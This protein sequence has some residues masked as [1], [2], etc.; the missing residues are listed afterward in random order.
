[1][2]VSCFSNCTGSTNFEIKIKI[3]KKKILDSSI[4]LSYSYIYHQNFSSL[5]NNFTF[6]QFQTNLFLIVFY[7]NRK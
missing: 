3:K 7:K 2:S 5:Q 4:C 6:E 1:M